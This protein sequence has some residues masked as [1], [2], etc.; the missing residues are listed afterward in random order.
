MMK[1]GKMNRCGIKWP[2]DAPHNCV[3]SQSS[4]QTHPELRQRGSGYSQEAVVSECVCV[5]VLSL[6]QS[7]SCVLSKR[8]RPHQVQTTTQQALE[9]EKNW[10]N[11]LLVACAFLSRVTA[12]S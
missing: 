7:D 9:E 3:N 2:P 11:V 6:N 4:R 10:T 5:C 8:S 1:D 12:V